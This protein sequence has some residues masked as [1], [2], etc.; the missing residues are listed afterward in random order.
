MAKSKRAR[1]LRAEAALRRF[2]KTKKEEEEERSETESEE[3]E[4]VEE[5]VGFILFGRVG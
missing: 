5:I 1:D 2:E 4:D 3:E